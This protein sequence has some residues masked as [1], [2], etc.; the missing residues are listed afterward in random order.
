MRYCPIFNMDKLS[1]H[2]SEL[3]E[4]NIFVTGDQSVLNEH[5]R[6]KLK[7]SCL[8]NSINPNIGD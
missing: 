2:V 6:E 3:A 5:M 1:E 4:D 7:L 8:S